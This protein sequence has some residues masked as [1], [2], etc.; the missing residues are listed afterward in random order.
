M[1]FYRNECHLYNTQN[2][3]NDAALSLVNIA[4]TLPENI[5]ICS[6][7]AGFYPKENYKNLVVLTPEYYEDLIEPQFFIYYGSEI[8]NAII[9]KLG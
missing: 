7:I 2:A 3:I 8:Y 1:K 4:N 9:K 6:V 5:Y